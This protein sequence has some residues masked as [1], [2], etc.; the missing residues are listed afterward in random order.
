MFKN[1]KE[2]NVDSDLTPPD[3]GIAARLAK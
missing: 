1:N 2:M 3:R